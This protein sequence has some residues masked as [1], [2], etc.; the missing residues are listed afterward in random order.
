[1][2]LDLVAGIISLVVALGFLGVLVYEVHSV[3]LWIVILLGAAMMV[4]SL[5]EVR[6]SDAAE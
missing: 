2:I 5:I 1:V 6:R 4:A 3:P